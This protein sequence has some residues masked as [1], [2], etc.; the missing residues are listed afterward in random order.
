MIATG[1]T[2]RNSPSTLARS[3]ASV[4]FTH[5][6]LQSLPHP[7]ETAS[8]RARALARSPARLAIAAPIVVRPGGS[9]CTATQSARRAAIG[10][11][12][13][14]HSSAVIATRRI[15]SPHLHPADT[16]VDLF[17]TRAALR[18]R[19]CVWCAGADGMEVGDAAERAAGSVRPRTFCAVASSCGAL[20]GAPRGR[21]WWE[22][23][24]A[25]M[26]QSALRLACSRTGAVRCCLR[27]SLR[28]RVGVWCWW[29][30]GWTGVDAASRTAAGSGGV[31][32]RRLW[33]LVRWDVRYGGGR[34]AGAAERASVAGG[35]VFAV[36]CG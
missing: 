17:L 19:V 12:V 28:S 5:S 3:I 34:R 31:R 21:V 13:H 30:M 4:I 29:N 24:G 2:R 1:P 22:C 35:L 14:I 18:G 10:G 16:H 7:A 8:R 36:R 11:A 25:W 15:P 23:G 6:R 26:L 33:F 27:C 32:Y 20:G 9:S